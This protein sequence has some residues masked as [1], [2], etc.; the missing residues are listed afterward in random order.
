MA[1]YAVGDLQG[2]LDELKAL[3]A[4]VNFGAEDQLWL[5]GDLVNRGPQSLETLRFVKDLGNQARA[6]LGNHD[7]HLLAVAFGTR[8]ATRK[9]TFDA[10][11]QAPDRDELLQWLR[12]LPLL[13]QDTAKGYLMVHAGIPPIWSLDQATDYAREVEAV[14]QSPLACE[15]FSNMYGN[16]PSRWKDSLDGWPRLRLITNYFTR[17]RFCNAKGKLELDTKTGLQN[18]PAGYAPWFSFSNRLTAA[19]RILFGHWAALEGR[20]DAPN[21]YPLDTG[22]VWGGRLTA[23]RLEDETYFSVPCSSH[24]AGHA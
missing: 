5:A 11:L 12:H 20:A 3:L 16:E 7:L 9:D 10:I 8:K 14:L 1:T 22:C 23:L 24:S 2:C 13:H 17:M 21:I 18:T 6:V 19:Q 15:F 4:K